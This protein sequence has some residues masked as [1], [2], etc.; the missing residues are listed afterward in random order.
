MVVSGTCII[1]K[2]NGS[3]IF[4]V[5]FTEFFFLVFRSVKRRSVMT[6]W[7]FRWQS[8]ARGRH[9]GSSGVSMI[10]IVHHSVL[11]TVIWLRV[12]FSIVRVTEKK[13]ATS[14]T[15]NIQW[16]KKIL[17]ILWIV[18]AIIIINGR[19]LFNDLTPGTRTSHGWTEEDINEQH[20]GEK[21]SKSNTKPHQPIWVSRTESGTVYGR[22]WKKMKN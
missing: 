16:E 17:P 7:V 8:A 2:R 21:D 18:N 5:K 4:V 22:S 9:L 11:T 1:I 12:R 15:S 19:F 6:L 3:K 10:T 14:K 20:D 13:M